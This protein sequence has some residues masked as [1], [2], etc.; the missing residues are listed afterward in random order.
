MQ[1]VKF[2][3]VSGTG[4]VLD[5]S[6]YIFL[7]YKL[8]SIVAYANMISAIPAVTFVF[9]VSTRKIFDTKS[10]KVPLGAKYL[11]YFFYQILLVSIVSFWGQ[12][13][14]NFILGTFFME[15]GWVADNLKLLTKVFITPITMIM[16]FLVLKILAEKL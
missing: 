2:L 7:T 14:Y 9:F 10:G 3:M 11:I 12:I 16:N 8:G 15:Y 13:L 6:V 5:F 1:I 4:W